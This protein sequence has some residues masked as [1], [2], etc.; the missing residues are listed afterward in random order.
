MNPATTDSSSS[1]S[2]S[3]A[4]SSF[5]FSPPPPASS[6]ASSGSGDELGQLTLQL[7][8]DAAQ[9]QQMGA[10]PAAEKAAPGKTLLI[11]VVDESGSMYGPY[12]R[13][14]VPA[15]IEMMEQVRRVC[16]V[17]C[18]SCVVCVSCRVCG[19]KPGAVVMRAVVPVATHGLRDHS[20]QQQRSTAQVRGNV[21]MWNVM[22]CNAYGMHVL[23]WNVMF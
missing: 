9:W 21:V 17:A 10:G 22:E 16:R 14:V 23:L 2:S 20:L 15:M 8:C 11:L 18:V 7:A 3:S 19:S 6:S 12:E 5:Y 4:F 13:Q 1:S